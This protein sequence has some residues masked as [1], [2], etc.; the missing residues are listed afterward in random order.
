MTL[1]YPWMLILLMGLGLFTWLDYRTNRLSMKKRGDYADALF[2]ARYWPEGNLKWRMAGQLCWLLAFLLLCL[3][4]ARPQGERISKVISQPQRVGYLVI[5]AS[6]SMEV[7]D[8]NGTRFAQ[9]EKMAAQIIANRPLDRLGLILFRKTAEQICPATT[10][11][12]ALY[13]A[14]DRATVNEVSRA[15]SDI[16]NALLLAIEKCAIW[17]KQ[18]K[19]IIL[20]S[21]GEHHGPAD[22]KEVARA[23]AVAKVTIMTIGVGS[24]AGGPIVQGQ[25]MWG[26]NIYKTYRDKQV[27]STL[28]TDHLLDIARLSQG[29]YFHWQQT[30][31]YEAINRFVATLNQVNGPVQ[32]GVVREWAYGF[33][34]AAFILLLLESIMTGWS[35]RRT[36]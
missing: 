13:L 22:W 7:A 11:H 16:E 27:I 17:P 19:Y 26:K 8:A 12:D 36:S 21:D 30:M 9:A 14:L 31:L 2:L 23:A 35:L 4:L 32:V 29:R 20:L 24:K 3:A 33:I 5:D 6:S 1:H 25:T 28:R 15:G 10:D 34:L 18:D